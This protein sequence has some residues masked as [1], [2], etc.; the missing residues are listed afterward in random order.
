M[1]KS[2]WGYNLVLAVVALGSPCSGRGRSARISCLSGA[3]VRRM[4]RPGD[5]AGLGGR[6]YR[7]VDG[8]LPA[9]API[10]RSG[11][12]APGQSLAGSGLASLM[13]IGT[14]PMLRVPAPALVTS[15]SAPASST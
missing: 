7:T 2:G 5:P 11:L 12:P 4:D 13:V 3:T 9:G 1:A 15:T 10:G 14:V 6:R 8:R